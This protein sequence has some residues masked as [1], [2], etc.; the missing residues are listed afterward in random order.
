MEHPYVLAIAKQFAQHEDPIKAK[1]AAKYLHN[2]FA[3]YG[4]P[5]PVRRQ[6]CK[7]FYK[8]NPVHNHQELEQIIK[9]A[10][11]SEY[12]EMQYFA[13]ELLGY[14]TKL[15]NAKTYV[16][17]EWMLS[18]KSWWDSVDSLNSFVI[19]KYFQQYPT[20]REK[21]TRKWNRSTNFWWQ[22]MSILFQLPYKTDTDLDL[23]TEY[24][25]YRLDEKEFFV[26]KAI[27]WALRQFAYTDRNWVKRF[28][29]EHPNLAPLSKREALKHIAK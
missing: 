17:I 19:S 15:W 21:I 6:V 12:R 11:A 8:A 2:Q 27:G 13:I 10:F 3:F 23:L 22:R 29:Q 9:E 18:N 14:H 25:E 20:H 7:A 26:Q 1:G 28:V 16:L 4:L 5:T 24:I